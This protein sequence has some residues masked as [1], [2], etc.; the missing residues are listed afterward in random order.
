MKR[1][2]YCLVVVL[3][4]V[5]TKLHAENI[6]FADANVKALCVTNWDTNGDGELSED[7]AAAVTSIGTVFQNQT[8]IT[9][10]SEFKFFTGV[11][12]IGQY[13]LSGCTKLATIEFPL[14]LQSFD[15]YACYNSG[16]ANIV[17]PDNVT[18]IGN[19]AF[20]NCTALST[21]KTGKNFVSFGKNVFRSCTSLS[22]ITFDGT[23]CHFNGEDAFRDCGA[24]T[25][26]I[27]TDVSAWCKSSFYSNPLSITKSLLLQTSDNE[28]S[29]IKDLVIPD[30]ITTI[31]SN[32]FYMCESLESVVIPNSVTSIGSYSFGYCKNLTS[33]TISNNVTSIG[34]YAFTGCSALASV[35]IP[36]SVTSI[37]NYAFQNCSTLTSVSI[38]KSLTSIGEYVFRGCSGLVSV[39]IP[40]SVTS[41][42]AGAFYECDGL[43]FV[44]IPNRVTSIG[45]YAFAGC[46]NLTSVR[47]EATTP[48]TI[49]SYVFSNRANATLYVPSGCKSSYETA[50]YWK[51]FKEIVEM[52]SQLKDGDVFTAK[53]S[54]NIDMTFKVISESDKTC[55]VDNGNGSAAI[56]T[57]YEGNLTIPSVVY[58]YRVISIGYRSLRRTNITS[59]VIPNGIETIST[60][61][62]EQCSKLTSLDI[63]NGIKTIGAEAFK[64][65]STLETSRIPGSVQTIYS[66]VFKNCYKLH[67]VFF[68]DGI[69]KVGS[70]MFE[71]C[72]SLVS[73]N[74]PNSINSIEAGAFSQCS[75]LAEITIPQGTSYIGSYAFSG[76]AALPSFTI[77]SEIKTIET[78]VFFGCTKLSSIVIP[79]G[80][81]TIEGNAFSGCTDLL[82]IE[83]PNTLE[84]IGS[85]AF[86][87]TKWYENQP[88]GVVYIG[89]IAYNYKGA[90][91]ENT[92]IKIAEGTIGI[93]P[94]AF[95]SFGNLVEVD[96]PESVVSIGSSCFNGCSGLTKVRVAI[97]N[98]LEIDYGTFSNQ[99]NAFLYVPDGCVD[100]YSKATVWKDFLSIKQF[101][102]PEMFSGGN[103]TESD[104]YIINTVG[105]MKVLSR[106]VNG[107]TSYEGVFFKVG[108]S[109]L[110]FSGVSYTAIGKTMYSS[111]V[112]EINYAFHG[113][114]DGNG[115]TIKN[116]STEKGLFGYIGKNGVVVNITIDESC[117][118]N[119]TTSNVA[120]IAGSNK[121]S[122][123][124][125][126]NKA[127]ILCTKYHVAG[128]C[129][130]NMGTITRCKNYGDIVCT[131]NDAFMIGGIAGDLDGGK[132]QYCD[133]YGN[134]SGESFGIGGIAGLVLR[135]NYSIENCTNTGDITGNYSVGGIIGEMSSGTSASI[136][137]NMVTSCTITSTYTSSEY[138]G[139]AIGKVSNGQNNFYTQDVILRKGNTVYD[140][141]TPRGVWGY[142]TSTYTYIPQDI[143]ENCAAMLL[144]KGDINKDS[145][146]DA[147]DASLVLQYV[148]KKIDTI[149]NADV[150]SDGNVDAQDAS[151]ILQYVA[152]KISW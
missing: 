54:D 3:T 14:G 20:R 128:I 58:G 136:S 123:D 126:I 127:S 80:V 141:L 24:L 78:S 83:F 76:C 94:S 18:S 87:N 16:F 71:N 110:D 21:F 75:G 45:K 39:S 100:I 133:N 29:V 131:S 19:S 52:P 86:N 98:P 12:T 66:E 60:E 26:I 109:E 101:T 144:Q 30:D 1:Y 33:V 96:I 148:A 140:G 62:F 73:V 149:Q 72:S 102:D 152:K 74:L 41:I 77:P 132:I 107:G 34:T 48:I 27:I 44:S 125:C 120:G 129:G 36:N 53:T 139:G 95:R 84:Y 97:I 51:E 111:S 112:N 88:D 50:N 105:D 17:I 143:T 42:G 79:E 11:T 15:R 28:I 91:P 25:S 142:D 2:I 118:I 117:K 46:T 38:S 85:M 108:I 134:V 5:S 57:D 64:T 61:A 7:E 104:P 13:A 43:T 68:E 40:N 63:P 146:I 23:E 115:V 81:T 82:S 59:V 113:H 135:E 89:K 70:Y 124:N 93:S 10:F 116:L 92:S 6:V 56:S 32:A 103:G 90:M 122:I 9:S 8:E 69:T 121:G 4:C 67:T 151:L 35:V 31:N 22:S 138:G 150:N 145:N 55:Q 99:G 37:G 130:D 49:D 47:V 119:S 65:C 106:D 114:F 137:N 147:Q